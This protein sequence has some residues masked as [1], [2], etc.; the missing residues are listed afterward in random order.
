MK[1]K[2]IKLLGATAAVLGAASILMGV[3]STKKSASGGAAAGAYEFAMVAKGTIETTVTS[4][5]VL[6]TVSSVSVL[7]QMSG[8]V[9]KVYADFNDHVKKGQLLVTLNTDMLELEKKEALA[10]LNIAQVNYDLAALDHQNNATLAAKGLVSEYDLK[11]SKSAMDVKKASLQSAQSALQVIETQLTH[12]A[13]IVSPIDGIV[14]ERDVEAGG[15]VVEGSSSNA[16]ALF[17]I[18]KDLSKMEIKAEVDELDIG[19]VKVGQ[20]S[21]F[22]VEA[23]PGKQYEGTVDSIRLVPET[24]DSV[25][26]YSVIIKADNDDGSLLPGMTANVEFIKERRE[27]VL[28]VPSAALRYQPASLSAKEIARMEYAAGLGDVSETARAAALAEYD[29]AQTASSSAKTASATK[30]T[31]LS[32]IIGGVPGGPGMHRSGSSSGTPGAPS[33]EPASGGAASSAV[34]KALWYLDA[35][36]K[37]AVKM[38]AVGSSDGTNTEIAGADEIEGSRVIVREAKGQA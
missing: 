33:S 1:K 27:S 19:S 32:G 6:E 29:A 24:T 21:R 15:S 38:V 11:S 35:Q 23:N 36:G 37:L 8:R 13:R 12:Y 14:L 26:N 18:A 9:E 4:S 22:T 16:T 28:L 31:G 17:T 25:V 7:S 2:M 10:N 30:T 3:A 5:G 20:A 34:K